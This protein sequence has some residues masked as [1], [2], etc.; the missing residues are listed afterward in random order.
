[1]KLKKEHVIIEM[2]YKELELAYEDIGSSGH[3]NC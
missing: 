1:M 3:A 2:K